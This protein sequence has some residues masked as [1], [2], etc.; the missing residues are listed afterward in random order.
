LVE[1]RLVIEVAKPWFDTRCGG[2]SLCP[3]ERHLILLLTLGR[4]S[5]PFVEANLTKDMQTEQLLC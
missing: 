3:Y 1:A 5:L 2:V 4:S